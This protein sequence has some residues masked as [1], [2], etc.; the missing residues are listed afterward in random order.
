MIFMLKDTNVYG[1]PS[2]AYYTEACRTRAL[3]ERHQELNLNDIELMDEYYSELYGQDTSTGADRS[4]IREAC[5]KLDVKKMCDEYKLID[6][7]GQCTVIV[8]YAAKRE[9]FESLLK[10]IRAQITALPGNKWHY[11]RISASTDI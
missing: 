4:E 6:S 11:A 3:A 8:P 10:T 9:E 1:F 2:S 7:T 5:K